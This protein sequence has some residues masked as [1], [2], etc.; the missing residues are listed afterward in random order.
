MAVSPVYSSFLRAGLLCSAVG[1]WLAVG[2]SP[3]VGAAEPVEAEPAI[4][5][6][7]A[8]EAARIT[9]PDIGNVHEGA[10]LIGNGD[11]NTLVVAQGGKI[12]LRLT[13]NDVWDARLDTAADPPLPT[14]A[15][16]KELAETDWPNRRRIL[17]EGSTWK[18]RDSYESS[19]NPCPRA[20]AWVFIGSR[21]E[22]ADGCPAMLDLRRAVVHVAGSP[23]VG[24]TADIRALADRNVFLIETAEPVELLPILSKSLPPATV[25]A[26][27]GASWIQQ[28]IPGDLDW[29]GM[30]FAVA[31]ASAAGRTA[32]AVVT[33]RESD[34]PVTDA[35]QLARLTVA[36]ER[37][38]LIERHERIWTE[39]WS[40]SGIDTAASLFCDAWYRNLYFLRCVT[41]RGSIAP[42]LFA[43]LISDKPAWHGDYHMNINLQQTFWGAY[44]T[45]HADMAEPYDRLISEYLPRARWIARRVFNC[46]GAYFPYVMF[47]Y[48]PPYPERCVSPNGRQYLHHVWS[49]TIG[50]S[51]F[52]VQ[53]LW[54][55]YKYAPDN[56]F[57]ESTAYP[58]VRDVAVFYADF[59]DKCDPAPD[60]KV[61][62]APSVSPEHWGWTPMFLRNRNCAFD[63][64]MIRFTLQAAIEGAITLG[65]DDELV[66]RFRR[67]LARLPDY[68]TTDDAVEPVVV[69]VLGALPITYNLPVPAFPVFPCGDV[70]HQS[71]FEQRV[72]FART[73]ARLR[74]HPAFGV[75]LLA[76][77]RARLD[78]DDAHQW[79]HAEVLPR[80]RGNGMML[81]VPDERTHPFNLL[82]PQN[83][84]FGGMTAAISELLLQS[85]GD[86]V[87]VLPA[88]AEG[89][90][91]R[92]QNLRAR[93]GFLVSAAKTGPAVDSF[94]IYSTVGGKL[95]LE[96]PWPTIV[97]LDAD[98]KQTTVLNPD[99]R[100]IVELYTTPGQRLDFRPR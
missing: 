62:L 89:E 95:Q 38:E 46:G 57:L 68:P 91:V 37:G 79:L 72:L 28:T 74:R 85:A 92:F 25:A 14:L 55:H 43:G 27:G 52:A 8:L 50:V 97:A 64:G 36:A 30:S 90:P 73:V 35:L 81:S 70:T 54:W 93:G 22:A 23:D 18:G 99:R 39:F 32:L 2:A 19:G 20:C 63:I 21:A 83:Q 76:I 60:G 100:R 6:P 9:V 41:K 48:E 26:S 53:P 77:A 13:K 84:Q 82:G 66:E 33:S 78:M 44:V 40:A 67:T 98:T 7:D 88:W 15:R 58:A 47:A 49:F 11:I 3:P 24:P 87:R 45:N 80:M 71:P 34:S 69:D 56:E 86:L 29:P 16:L 65:R 59:V 17:P 61:V 4:P 5:F 96:S 75:E 10:L 42:G 12:F 94:S 31:T 1:V 51:G